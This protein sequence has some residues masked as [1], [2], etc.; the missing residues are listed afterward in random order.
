MPAR[1]HF[2]NPSIALFEPS[3]HSLIDRLRI[4]LKDCSRYFNGDVVL[5]TASRVAAHTL[6]PRLKVLNASGHCF[7]TV[8]S[9]I[10]ALRIENLREIIAE[11]LNILIARWLSSDFIVPASHRLIR[12]NFYHLM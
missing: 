3:Q 6:G 5:R 8:L 2:E 7:S 9:R 4:V 11:R 12:S 1:Q 10:L